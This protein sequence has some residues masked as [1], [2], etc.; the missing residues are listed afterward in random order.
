MSESHRPSFDAFAGAY[1]KHAAESAYNAF[2]DRPAVLSLLEPVSGR[3]ILDAG[4]GPGFYAEDLVNRGAEVVGFDESPE[5]IRLADKRLGGRALFRVHDLA[6]PIN[7]IEDGEFDLALMALV[8]HHIDDRVGAL[9]E[10]NRVLRNGG[11]LVV[12]THHPMSDW[13]R[14]GGSYFAVEK[15]HEIWQESWEVSFWRQPLTNTCEEFARAGFVIE[16][17][18]EPRP[19]PQ[20]ADQYPNDHAALTLLPAFIAFRLRKD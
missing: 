8:I 11:S 20:M 15:V 9:R 1:E 14:M 18:I 5:M 19:A 12:S 3:R 13:L 7:W 10:L 17:L 6:S 2:Y 16:R 4:C